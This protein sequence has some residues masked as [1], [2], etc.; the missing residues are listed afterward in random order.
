[1][2]EVTRL[3]LDLLGIQRQ[4]GDLTTLMLPEEEAMCSY[5][6]SMES[7]PVGPV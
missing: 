7:I 3:G 4:N 2:T 6:V 5:P 1:M